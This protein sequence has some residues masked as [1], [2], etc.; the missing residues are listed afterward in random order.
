MDTLTEEEIEA[1]AI[2]LCE[3][4][5]DMLG[6]GFS[7]R[8]LVAGLGNA[9]LTADSVG[10]KAAA[11]V[12]PT[13]H[14]KRHDPES[15]SELECC[16]IAVLIPGV[17]ASSG[18][19]SAE[20]IS[21]ICEKIK[22]DA[23]IAIDSLASRSEE[24]LGKTIQISNTGIFPGS[25]VGNTRLPLNERSVGAP[26]FAIGVPTVIDARIFAPQGKERAGM[27]KNTEAMF[28]SPKEIDELSAASAKI[29]ALGINKAF[30][31]V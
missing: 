11:R 10:P 29:I 25:G 27:Q 19:D 23:V 7:G 30:G 24:R 4:L 12:H 8:L 26:V 22:P 31:I 14:I 21:G 9:R 20:I 1:A 6:H 5:R 15:F 16:E 2:L 18:L 13:M 3:E 28:V 17:C